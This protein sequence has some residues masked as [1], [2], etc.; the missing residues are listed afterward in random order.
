MSYNDNY[1]IPSFFQRIYSV[2]MRHIRV[3][4]SEFFSNAVP[5]FFE[6][7]ITLGGLGIGLGMVI[8]KMG[9]MSYW[10]FLA[11]GLLVTNAMFMAAYECSFGTFIRLEFRKIYDGMLGAPLS[12]NDII[13]GEILFTGTK[14]L[15]FSFAFLVVAWITGIITY[16]LSIMTIF[17]GFLTGIMFAA[18]SMFI[19]SFITN[20]TH[21]NFYFTGLLNPM[22]FLSGVLFP[23]E[24]L[25]KVLIWIAECMPMTHA[26]R[27]SRAFC[28]PGGIKPHLLIDLIYCILFTFFFG[29]ISIK[30]IKKRLII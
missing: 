7:I 6:P 28:I 25:P 4:F 10:L 13:I 17:I 3:Y 27:L 24:N 9:N 20:I 14:G 12:P 22:F 26:V 19:T 2:W 30:R 16:P 21:F 18:L 1:P 8:P 15:F 29:W 11:S 5:P 23:V